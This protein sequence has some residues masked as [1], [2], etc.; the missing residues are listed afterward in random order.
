[1]HYYLVKSCIKLVFSFTCT[2]HE[3]DRKT[4]S[5]H[6]LSFSRPVWT[7]PVLGCDKSGLRKKRDIDQHERYHRG[8]AAKRQ[9]LEE[10]MGPTDISLSNRGDV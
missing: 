8:Q 10:V 4:G 1:M 2:F 3:L 7:C 9:R 5:M 6:S